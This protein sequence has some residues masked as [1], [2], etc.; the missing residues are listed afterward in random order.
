MFFTGAL[1]SLADSF[2]ARLTVNTLGGNAYF[3]FTNRTQR[4]SLTFVKLSRIVGIKCAHIFCLLCMESTT[5]QPLQLGDPSLW[6]FKG[7]A[8]CWLPV[9]WVVSASAALDFSA[10]MWRNREMP[11][12]GTSRGDLAVSWS[13]WLCWVFS[14]FS[15]LLY[16]CCRSAACLL[17][18]AQRT[19]I[20]ML[21]R[22]LCTCIWECIH[23]LTVTWDKRQR[24]VYELL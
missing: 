2:A 12:L 20:Q 16:H 10:L 9:A 23:P 21:P 1:R 15:F 8:I 24:L 18:S 11:S 7:E 22:Y 19:L 6:D 14:V 13:G 17:W 5:K 3:V 4:Y